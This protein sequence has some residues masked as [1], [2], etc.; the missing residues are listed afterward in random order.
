MSLGSITNTYC[1]RYAPIVMLILPAIIMYL[2]LNE[3]PNEI[4]AFLW[5]ILFVNSLAFLVNALN[6]I[7]GFNRET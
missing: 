5:F 3:Q 7:K 6:I 1:R 2:I 4:A